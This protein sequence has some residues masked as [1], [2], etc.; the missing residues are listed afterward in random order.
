LDLDTL[1]IGDNKTLAAFFGI[2]FTRTQ[3]QEEEVKELFRT[4]RSVMVEERWLRLGIPGQ[5]RLI[6]N[7]LSF[8]NLKSLTI[9]ED[10]EDDRRDQTLEQIRMFSERWKEWAEWRGA[11]AK[12]PKVHLLSKA[13]MQVKFKVQC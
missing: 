2:H 6:R 11:D 13:A 7:F 12:S 8:R 1:Y 10:S 4:V 9:L 3:A 5:R